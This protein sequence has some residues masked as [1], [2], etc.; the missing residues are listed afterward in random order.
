MPSILLLGDI[1]I[2]KTFNCISNKI[3]PEGPFPVIN[4][5]VN[6]FVIPAVK[7]ET[8]TPLR[9]YSVLTTPNNI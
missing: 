6:G 5:L 8:P 4:I 9:K 7:K 1:V 2:Y 3:A